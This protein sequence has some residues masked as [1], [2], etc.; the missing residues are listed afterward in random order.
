MVHSRNP[1]RAEVPWTEIHKEFQMSLSF[2]KF[3]PWIT[4]FVGCEQKFPPE[5]G[6]RYYS[7]NNLNNTGLTGEIV[8]FTAGFLRAFNLTIPCIVYLQ[9]AGTQQ[10]GTIFP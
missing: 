10:L 3:I 4:I 9:E 2:S 7:K 5:R 8:L 1:L 6:W